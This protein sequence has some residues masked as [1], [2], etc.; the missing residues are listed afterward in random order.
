MTTDAGLRAVWQ[1]LEEQRAMTPL[2]SQK[3]RACGMPNI[4]K[5]RTLCLDCNDERLRL[6]ERFD[7]FPIP[8]DVAH[9]EE[10]LEHHGERRRDLQQPTIPVKPR[11]EWLPYK[12]GDA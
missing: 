7:K 8:A 12:D 2:S 3:C 5:G 11:E 1:R 9:T 6:K 10:E 4:G